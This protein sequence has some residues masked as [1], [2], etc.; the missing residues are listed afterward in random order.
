MNVFSLIHDLTG[1][2][3]VMVFILTLI[4]YGVVSAIICRTIVANG[5]T[6]SEG[7]RLPILGCGVCS[8]F[9][10]WTNL[11]RWFFRIAFLVPWHC[12]FGYVFYLYLDLRAPDAT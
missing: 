11:N 10:K 4:A 2:Y 3:H 6:L 9:E 7:N 1:G 5:Y 12:C 8:G